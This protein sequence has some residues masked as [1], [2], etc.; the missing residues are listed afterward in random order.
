MITTDIYNVLFDS[1]VAE[2]L[3]KKSKN[4]KGSTILY[5]RFFSLFPSLCKK[6]IFGVGGGSRKVKFNTTDWF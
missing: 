1:R 4:F 6:R 5:T 2:I 3:V